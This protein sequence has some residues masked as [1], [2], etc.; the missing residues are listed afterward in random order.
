MT[1]SDAHL[2]MRR[3]TFERI[4]AR[5]RSFGDDDLSAALAP[6]KASWR[7]SVHGSQS[8]VIEVEGAKVF[9]K[10]ISLTDL[11]RRP[12]NEGST[13]NLFGLPLFYQYGVG[14]AGFG[15]WRELQAY[16]KAGEWALSG[17]CPHFPLVYHWRVL[18][19]RPPPLSAEQLAWLERAPDYWESDAVRA[20]LEAISGATSSIVLFL[21]HVPQMLDTWLSDSL[22]GEPPAPGL[23]A[24]ILRVHEQLDETAAFMN[25][26][27]MLHFDLHA[28]N[29]LTDGD[30][31]YAAD[32]GLAL[33]EDFDLSPAERGFFEAHRLYDRGYVAW[34]LVE[35]LAPK[36]E[37]RVR[38]PALDALVA[39]CKPVADILRSFFGRLSGEAK[40]TPY[41]AAEL[42]AALAQI[43]VQ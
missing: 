19:R 33:C 2:D 11:E 3:R 8:A 36:G 4:A 40:T 28:F 1:S 17:E 18:P 7:Y 5:L 39:R 30:Q 31:V 21:E 37:P 6:D 43:R 35:C 29:V 14:S 41:P 16:L 22:A 13:A 42:E 20:R 12:E 38:A 26:R 27:G 32:F 15:A 9:V 34:G 24:A 25:G 23:E 10:Q